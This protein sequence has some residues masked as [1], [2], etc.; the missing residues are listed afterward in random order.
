MT[1]GIRIVI[2]V[3]IKL[4]EICA[5]SHTVLVCLQEFVNIL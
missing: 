1:G 5:N 3:L 2:V 4:F